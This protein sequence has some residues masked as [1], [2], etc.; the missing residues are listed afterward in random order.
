M[1]NTVLQLLNALE[2]E[3][4]RQQ[5]W[6][7][8]PPDV[9]ALQSTLPF[10][11]DTMALEQWLQFVFLPRLQAL[12]DTHQ[13]LPKKV[14]ILPVAELAFGNKVPNPAMLLDIIRRIDSSLSGLA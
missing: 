5:L 10:C 11:Y 9:T 6:S 14:S 13:A 1:S 3:L 12:L 8:L 2:I 7:A 4:K